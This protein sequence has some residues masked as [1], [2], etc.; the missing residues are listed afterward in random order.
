MQCCLIASSTCVQYLYS[1]AGSTILATCSYWLYIYRPQVKSQP[2]PHPL[3]PTHAGTGS[4]S[5]ASNRTCCH[6]LSPWFTSASRCSGYFLSEFL[7]STV[8]CLTFPVELVIN[9]PVSTHNANKVGTSWCNSGKCRTKHWCNAPERHKYSPGARGTRMPSLLS[10]WHAS[11]FA[12]QHKKLTKP[13]C[14]QSA[15]WVSPSR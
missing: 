9:T 3:L 15:V 4:Y 11:A 13:T 7:L 10:A 8:G 1:D 12:C 2:A 14:S 6:L 5:R